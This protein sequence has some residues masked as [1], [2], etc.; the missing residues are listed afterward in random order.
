MFFLIKGGITQG[1]GLQGKL[2]K[3]TEALEYNI[4]NGRVFVLI[5]FLTPVLT[6]LCKSLQFI[7]SVILLTNLPL[8]FSFSM[9][10]LFF[11]RRLITEIVSSRRLGLKT[12]KCFS[13]YIDPFQA[14]GGYIRPI[15]PP[16]AQIYLFYD[17]VLCGI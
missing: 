15:F 4:A 9:I 6:V 2:D 3:K 7:I 14:M 8:N 5:Y 13:R 10:L 11:L 17:L 12:Q 16:S 1:Q